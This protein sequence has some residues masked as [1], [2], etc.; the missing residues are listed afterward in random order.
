[1][2]VVGGRTLQLDQGSLQGKTEDSL[3]DKLKHKIHG[4]YSEKNAVHE[5]KTILTK[6]S[7]IVQEHASF[8]G[9]D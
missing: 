2:L 8:S 3:S 9:R 7:T 6:Q 4:F 1:M 5:G